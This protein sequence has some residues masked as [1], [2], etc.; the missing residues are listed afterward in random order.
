MLAVP[1]FLFLPRVRAPFIVGRGAGTGAAIESGGFS[2][3]VTIDSIGRIRESREVALRLLEESGAGAPDVGGVGAD[4]FRG[5]PD[6]VVGLG[7]PIAPEEDVGR[8]GG[9]VGGR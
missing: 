1:L 8:R 2:D 4:P 9:R 5:D 7:R 3:E 6:V